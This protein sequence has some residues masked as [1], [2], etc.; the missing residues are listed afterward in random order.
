M[1]GKNI[2]K[3]N[4]YTLRLKPGI[5][6]GEFLAIKLFLNSTITIEKLNKT[7]LVQCFKCQSLEH[8]AANCGMEPKC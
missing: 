7:S 4:Y 5:P 3:F 6:I 8:V 1:K 2:E